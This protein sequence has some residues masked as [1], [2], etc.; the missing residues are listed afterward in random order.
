MSTARDKARA[1]LAEY[2]KGSKHEIANPL[3]EPTLEQR[4]MRAQ[5]MLS[6]VSGVA[7]RFASNVDTTDRYTRSLVERTERDIR[8][9]RD[10]YKS[11]L[12]ECRRCK[13]ALVGEIVEIVSGVTASRFYA[14]LDCVEDGDELA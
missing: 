2:L 3:A 14:H 4:A 8:D 6:F 10:L 7:V 12:G 9:I 1:E 13:H 5:S 11:E